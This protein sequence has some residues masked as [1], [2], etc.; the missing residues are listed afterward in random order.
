MTGKKLLI[1]LYYIHTYYMIQIIDSESMFISS[2]N[3]CTYNV[4][5]ILNV[6]L[7][8]IIKCSV[9]VCNKPKSESFVQNQLS[10]TKIFIFDLF[11]NN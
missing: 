9:I 10:V 4:H 1:L 2:N 8:K 3:Q 11:E 5:F 7:Y 6:Y